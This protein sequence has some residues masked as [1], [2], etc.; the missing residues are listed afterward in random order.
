MA[1][2][3]KR[4]VISE[5]LRSGS[6]SPIWRLDSVNTSRLHY[7]EHWKCVSHWPLAMKHVLT[8]HRAVDILPVCLRS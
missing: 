1:M 7:D 8:V 5:L 2:A 6:F 4:W 3:T